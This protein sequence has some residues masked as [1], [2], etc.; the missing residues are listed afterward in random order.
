[1]KKSV[2]SFLSFLLFAC[3]FIL[4]LPS[5]AAAMPDTSEIREGIRFSECVRPYDGGVL[6]ANYGSEHVPP[7]IDDRKGYILFRKN[8][9]TET[10][11]PDGILHN[12]SGMAVKDHYLFVCDGT[13][14]RVFDLDRPQETPQTI[15]FPAPYYLKA[16]AVDGNTLYVSSDNVGQIFTLDISHPEDMNRVK[17]VKWLELQGAKCMAV[18]GGVMYITA[19]PENGPDIA[20]ADMENVIYRVSDLR[21]PKAEKFISKK[22]YSGDPVADK[23]TSVYYEGITL[24]EDQYALYITDHRVKTGA[25]LVVDIGTKELRTIY[26]AE[27]LD[28]ADLTQA[29]KA[30]FIPDMK[31]HR[32]I[33]LEL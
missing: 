6:I 10:V 32:V 11:I 28:P 5:H 4:P 8:G 17:P 15:T 7:G 12:P 9:K 23:N 18:G 21:H 26:E 33:K 27:G 16:A 14:L 25:I 13:H 30:L 3:C 22:I 19:L 20:D 31:N 29:D 2:V 1:L 24:S